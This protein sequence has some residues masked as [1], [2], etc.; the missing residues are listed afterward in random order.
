MPKFDVFGPNAKLDGRYDN[1]PDVY[2]RLCELG[3]GTL[4]QVDGWIVYDHQ[5]TT[6]LSY[7]FMRDIVGSALVFVDAE[8]CG[9]YS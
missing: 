9:L 4:V 1:L 5:P 8:R 3:H 2:H 7:V 6:N